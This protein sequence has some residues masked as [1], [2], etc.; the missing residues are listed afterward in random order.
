VQ[1][2]GVGGAA[3]LDQIVCD[4]VYA[5]RTTMLN[6]G[7]IY[8]QYVIYICIYI[9]M[10]MYIYVCI[11]VCIYTYIYICVYITY[12]LFITYGDHSNITIL[13]SHFRL[14]IIFC[15]KCLTKILNG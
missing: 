4:W 11:Y 15:L 8:I 12:T 9:Y 2:R 5:E 14:S 13:I 1:L 6:I 3:W 10:Y 7:V